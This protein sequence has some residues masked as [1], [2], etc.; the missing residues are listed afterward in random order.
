[1]DNPPPLPAS[2]E[3]KHTAICAARY[4]GNAIPVMRFDVF[5]PCSDRLAFYLKEIKARRYHAFDAKG[6]DIAMP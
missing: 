3:I 4:A 5:P 6:A 1:M 2:G